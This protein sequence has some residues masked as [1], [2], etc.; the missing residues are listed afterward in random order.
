MKTK[1][2]RMSLFIFIVLLFANTLRISNEIN[3][4]NNSELE[5]LQNELQIII[6][7]MKKVSDSI[8]DNMINTPKVINI[9]KYAHNADKKE[10][11]RYRKQLY[12]LLRTKYQKFTN[13][14]IQQLH[15]HLPNNESFLRFH[16]PDKYGDNLTGIRQSVMYVNKH[17]KPIMGFEEGRILNGYRFVYPL[18]DDK[19]NHIGSVEVSSS[20][21]SFKRQFQDNKHLHLDYILNKEVVEK[22]VFQSQQK[23]YIPYSLSNKFLIQTT[24][25]KYND[26]YCKE[27]QKLIKSLVNSD[28]KLDNNKIEKKHYSK[29]IDFTMYSTFFIPLLNDF[30]GDKVGYTVIFGKSNYTKYFAMSVIISY[31]GIFVLSILIGYILYQSK[32]SL[33]EIEIKKQL[34]QETLT[35]Q[36]TKFGNRK[37][38]YES[39]NEQLEL[40]HRYGTIFSVILYDI[41]F[42]K[43]INDNYGHKMGDKVLVQMCDMIRNHVRKNDG[44]FRIGGEEFIV[45]LPQ[46]NLEHGV[47]FA[48]KIRNAVQNDLKTIPE[49]T[50][51]V[52]A[53]VAEVKQGDTEDSLFTRVDQYLYKAK[54]SGRN[55]VVYEK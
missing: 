37:A 24:L 12:H 3:N 26:K 22:K 53:G 16:S 40:F 41:D 7:D 29:V 42:F 11:E 4:Y 52:S 28:L 15:F 5:S 10:Q 44:L 54:N 43:S 9:F 48:D 32:K 51:T 46:T 2:V 6:H 49:K 34:K 23:N 13:Y 19:K 50:I 31:V 27:D 25:A 47:L 18:F 14:G 21:L 45:I 35:D 8:F 36:L 38:Y 20:L 30:S 1:Y 33:D 17:K 55:Q 39:L